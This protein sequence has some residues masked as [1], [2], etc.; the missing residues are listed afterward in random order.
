ME[1]EKIYRQGDVLLFK[2]KEEKMYQALSKESEVILEKGEVTGHMHRLKGNIEMLEHTPSNQ[3]FI[4]SNSNEI[5]FRVVE[6]AV[7]TH[8]E[9]DLLVLEK[10]IYLKIQQVEYNPFNNMT[11]FVMD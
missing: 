2:I 3:F 8:E 9:H 7:L 5:L 11:R 1:I 6:N 4:I 10:G